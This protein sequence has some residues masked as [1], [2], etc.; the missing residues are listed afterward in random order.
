MFYVKPG[1]FP[2]LWSPK[3]P[4][5][6][7]KK[8]KKKKMSLSTTILVSFLNIVLHICQNAMQSIFCGNWCVLPLVSVL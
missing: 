8:E 6:E 2:F 7:E 4:K 1:T 3:I 5:F